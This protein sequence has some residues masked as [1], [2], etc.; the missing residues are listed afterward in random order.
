M[1]PDKT[2]FSVMLRRIDPRG[3][4]YHNPGQESFPTAEEALSALAKTPIM[5]SGYLEWVATRTEWR[6]RAWNRRV[7]ARRSNLTPTI[8]RDTT[9]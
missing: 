2:T 3:I 1:K 6:G 9:L 5:P 4:E 8:S 7:I